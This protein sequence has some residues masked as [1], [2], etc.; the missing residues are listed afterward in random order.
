MKGVILAGGTGS[1]L[2]PLTKVT[3]KHLLPIY[4]RPMVYYPLQTMQAM[5]ITSVL[6]VSGK[7]HAGHFLELLGRGSEFG[8]HL[9]YEIQEEAGG[10]AQALNLAKNFVGQEKFVVIL[11]DNILLDDLSPE[12]QAFEQGSKKAHVFLSEVK[13]PQHYGVPRF[14]GENLV[15]IIEKPSQ[16]P[17]SYAVT[18][19]YCYTPEV[20]EVIQKLKPSARGE[21]EISDVNNHYVQTGELGYSFL[22]S[23]W[24]DCG[25]SID[26]MMEV[27]AKM[28]ALKG[29]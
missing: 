25:E 28:K 23:F 12:I 22:K 24:G 1:R 15:E 13:E 20:F 17:S 3:N 16:P 9:S 8:L 18:G 5:G 7:G 10:I 11:G 27:S 26:A 2:A 4:D 29:A 21:L 19:C 14:E 6:L